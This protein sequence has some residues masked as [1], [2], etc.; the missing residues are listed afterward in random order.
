MASAEEQLQAIRKEIA[1]DLAKIEDELAAAHASAL[2]AETT[3][4]AATEEWRLLSALAA[5]GGQ[6]VAVTGGD[7]EMTTSE[8]AAPFHTRLIGRRDEILEPARCARARARAEVTALE[9]RRG[10]L[11]DSIAQIDRAL[12][13]E[14]RAVVARLPPAPKRIPRIV[15]FDTV[16]RA[17]AK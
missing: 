4:R 16:E 8:L 14:S 5:R 10:T 3:H 15:E 1:G 6:S 11:L 12:S 7:G 13:G 2:L 9:H 17:A